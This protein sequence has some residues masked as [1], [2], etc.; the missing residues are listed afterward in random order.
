VNGLD[1]SSLYPSSSLPSQTAPSTTEIEG[2]HFTYTPYDPSLLA[3]ATALHAELEA[4]TNEVSR[5]RRG[6][7][8]EAAEGYIATLQ[9][10]LE[11]DEGVYTSEREDA[12]RTPEGVLK[13]ESIPKGAEELY[14]RGLGELVGLSGLSSK[15]GAGQGGKKQGTLS[16]TETVGKVQRARRVVCELE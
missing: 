13:V 14:E 4:L 16:L 2:Q 15:A 3:R 8:R 9:N 11:E 7:P 1:A 6:A 10:A 12:A 5:L